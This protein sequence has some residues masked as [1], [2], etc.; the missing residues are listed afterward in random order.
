MSIKFWT[1]RHRTALYN[2]FDQVRLKKFAV[3][4]GAFVSDM[5]DQKITQK[6]QRRIENEWVTYWDEVWGEEPSDGN[7]LLVYR[8]NRN[9]FLLLL[10]GRATGIAKAVHEKYGDLFNAHIE[11]AEEDEEIS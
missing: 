7:K 9:Q 10:A 8:I 2:T 5:L 3:L 4:E 6:A 1:P 11:D